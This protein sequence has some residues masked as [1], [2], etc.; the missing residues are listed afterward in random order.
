MGRESYSI[1]RV[2]VAIDQILHSRNLTIVDGI[3]KVWGWGGGEG[4]DG[5]GGGRGRESPKLLYHK[6]SVHVKMQGRNV[7]CMVYRCYCVMG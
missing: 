6:M 4:G 3:R 5:R 2:S 7:A 1:E